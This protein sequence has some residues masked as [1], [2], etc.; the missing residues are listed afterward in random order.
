MFMKPSEFFARIEER[1]IA[2]DEKLDR[3]MEAQEYT[4]GKVKDLTIWK[5]KLEGVWFA[6]GVMAGLV[7]T[8][9]G[10]VFAVLQLLIK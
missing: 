7:V 10:L 3:V 6:L 9:A 8:I 1:Q 4:N 2:M 5:A